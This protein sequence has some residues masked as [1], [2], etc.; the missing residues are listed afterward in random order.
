MNKGNA[1][2]LLYA[3]HKNLTLNSWNKYFV[4]NGMIQKYPKL[5]HSLFNINRNKACI[6]QLRRQTTNLNSSQHILRVIQHYSSS[7]IA[8]N[9]LENDQKLET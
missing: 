5:S 3:P 2:K 8:T 1:A 6:S 9:R 4:L 7:N